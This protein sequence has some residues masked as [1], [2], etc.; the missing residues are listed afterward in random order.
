MLTNTSGLRFDR[1]KWVLLA[2]GI[3]AGILY[4]VNIFRVFFHNNSLPCGDELLYL[5]IDVLSG[6]YPSLFRYYDIFTLVLIFTPLAAFATVLALFQPWLGVRM[7]LIFSAISTAGSLSLLV[8]ALLGYVTLHQFTNLWSRS[9]GTMPAAIPELCVL[10]LSIL[11][12]KSTK[13]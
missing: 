6:S 12:L 8:V 13:N 1:W 7:A 4:F 5:H 10:V 3:L 11:L 9:L 2:V